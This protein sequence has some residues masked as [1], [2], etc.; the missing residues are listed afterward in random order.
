MMG[1]GLKKCIPMNLSGRRIL[2]AMLVTER[3]E[4]FVANIVLSSLI[5]AN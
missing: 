4:V 3:E 1:A 2:L 5:V